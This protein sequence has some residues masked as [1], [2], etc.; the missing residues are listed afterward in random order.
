MYCCLLFIYQV[1][2]LFGEMYIR[3]RFTAAYKY[4][5]VCDYSGIYVCIYVCMVITYS[6]GKD[7]PG[8][9]A[10]PARGQIA[11]QGK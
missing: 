1:Y 8:K 3:A 7:Q 6:K 9:V 11:E 10:D 5:Y 2:F 4:T